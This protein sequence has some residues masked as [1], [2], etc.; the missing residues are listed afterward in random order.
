MVYESL[1]LSACYATSIQQAL[2]ARAKGWENPRFA[3][4]AKIDLKA[5]KC[6]SSAR[7]HRNSVRL[8]KRKIW[9]PAHLQLLW[10]VIFSS[11]GWF[12]N[13]ISNLFLL[14]RSRSA[15][16]CCLQHN[17]P[18]FSGGGYISRSFVDLFKCVPY[19]VFETAFGIF[20]CI[21]ET[22]FSLPGTSLASQL[23][24]FN[25]FNLHRIENHSNDMQNLIYSVVLPLV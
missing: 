1:S 16:I 25:V 2:R 4:R 19:S 14:S 5:W 3:E 22:S 17:F 23:S 9:G 8:L 7:W 24:H 18:F 20:F 21:H 6:G 15:H 12:N 13:T 10:C 11:V